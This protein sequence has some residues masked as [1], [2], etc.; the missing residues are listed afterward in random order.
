MSVKLVRR[1]LLV[2]LLGIA[3]VAH[4]EPEFRVIPKGIPQVVVVG[5]GG[6]FAG[7]AGFGFG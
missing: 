6:C 1:L 2:A 5:G 4:S 3:S 7:V